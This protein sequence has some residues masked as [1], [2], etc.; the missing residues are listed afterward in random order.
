[1]VCRAPSGRRP[2]QEI[3]TQIIY[4]SPSFVDLVRLGPESLLGGSCTRFLLNGGEDSMVRFFN[5]MTPWVTMRCL[6]PPYPTPGCP[7]AV[8]RSLPRPEARSRSYSRHKRTHAHTHRSSVPCSP[9]LSGRL[10]VRR[11]DGSQIPARAQ[12]QFF[13]DEE[14]YVRAGPAFMF[15]F[16]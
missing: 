12:A 7:F 3:V 1:M 8:G 10:M 6:E 11:G 15:L 5:E 14:G 4:T 13:Y 9:V 16:P 2:G